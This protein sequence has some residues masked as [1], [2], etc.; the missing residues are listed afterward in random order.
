MIIGLH[1]PAT[2]IPP[3][4]TELS[5]PVLKRREHLEPARAQPGPNIVNP[6]LHRIVRGH[7]RQ[8]EALIDEKQLLAAMLATPTARGI[9]DAWDP[10]AARQDGLRMDRP[11]FRAKKVEFPVG[12]EESG[13]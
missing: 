6:G 9:N 11:E 5:A 12:P 4:N 8:T 3:I 13:R 2:L 10:A 7:Q 1:N